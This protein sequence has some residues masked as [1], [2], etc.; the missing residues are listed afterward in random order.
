MGRG[1]GEREGEREKDNEAERE[2][3]REGS[4]VTIL[5]IEDIGSP[6]LAVLS[7]QSC[8]VLRHLLPVPAVLFFIPSSACP[9]LLVPFWLSCSLFFSAY[10]S[11]IIVL[12]R[13]SW[14]GCS[15]S[16]VLL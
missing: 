14:L 16:A 7:R 3:E 4:S 12:S 9:V 6:V 1:K 15:I 10:L 5:R 11:S 2:R 8:S 13:L